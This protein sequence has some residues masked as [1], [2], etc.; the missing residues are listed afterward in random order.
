LKKLTA[1]QNFLLPKRTMRVITA[2]LISATA[3]GKVDQ[4]LRTHTEEEYWQG[5]QAF[6]KISEVVERTQGYPHKAEH[7]YRFEIF[8]DSMEEI[9][10]HNALNLSWRKGITQFA[11]MTG[12]EF[13]A[14]INCYMGLQGKADG[15][16]EAAPDYT[17]Q[18]Q[19][20][21]WVTKGAVTPVK[22]QGGCGSCWA[23]STTGSI[24]G[25]CQ[26]STGTLT[27]LSEQNL[28]DCDTHDL[29][30]NGGLMDFAFEFVMLNGG[31]CSEEDY[32]YVAH[33]HNRCK[34]DGCTKYGKISSFTDVQRESANS[35]MAALDSQPVSIAIEADQGAFQLYTEGILDSNSCGN[36]LD[37]GVLAVGYGTE[38][39]MDY[40]KV[41]NSWGAGWGEDGYIRMCRNCGKNEG[42]GQCGIL[43]QPSYPH[44]AM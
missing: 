23:F 1:E 10:R 13:K 2:V 29:G 15:I 24:E 43:M 27:S 26:I 39:G 36:S 17:P 32:H 44:C 35:L 4:K 31:I 8:K 33:E 9:K 28:V 21:D 25:A 12:E 5:W 40:W 42:A 41:K 20:V 6:H 18:S 30:C 16:F 19:G 7:D 11:D 37:H 22:N 14:H 3:L 38:N 34:E